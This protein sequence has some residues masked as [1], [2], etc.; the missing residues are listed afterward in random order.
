MLTIDVLEDVSH[1]SLR[2]ALRVQNAREL[3]A[4]LLLVAENGQNLGVKVAITVA[5]YPELQT[6]TLTVSASGAEPVTLVSGAV[7][8]QE[9]PALGH[10]HTFQHD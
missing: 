8:A 4:F 2:Q 3:L 5:G 7:L 9:L 1:L 10:H 6:F